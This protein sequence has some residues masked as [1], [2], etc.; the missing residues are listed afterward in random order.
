MRSVGQL[1][2][3]FNGKADIGPGTSAQSSLDSVTASG[4]SESPVRS[5][6]SP[7]AIRLVNIEELLAKNDPKKL[8]QLA[9]QNDISDAIKIALTKNSHLSGA[10]LRILAVNA[11]SV[12]LLKNIRI[13][14]K[15]KITFEEL[16]G[17]PFIKAMLGFKLN[18]TDKKILAA[19]T[20]TVKKNR[21]AMAEELNNA[22]KKS[23]KK[24]SA[25]PAFLTESS[26]N[27]LSEKL[28]G[29]WASVN[30]DAEKEKQGCP[31]R[32]SIM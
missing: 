3:F 25:S 22:G 11:D 8:L 12:E 4:G 10:A 13:A 20:D 2:G 19:E 1:I 23:A 18:D 6:T 17:Y 30:S 14:A 9:K 26:V 31:C 5:P 32:C 24:R 16:N 21:L 7:N 28:V 29:D 27:N 15:N